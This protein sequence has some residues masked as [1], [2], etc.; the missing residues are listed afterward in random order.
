MQA[1]FTKTIRRCAN[2]LRPYDK[3][4][5]F[6]LNKYTLRIKD[7]E[8]DKEL[9]KRRLDRFH[10]LLNPIICLCVVTF[11]FFLAFDLLN[12]DMENMALICWMIPEAII[13]A[14]W[15]TFKQ[16]KWKKAPF[17]GFLFP[18]FK[19]VTLTL[20][21][22]GFLPPWI[23]KVDPEVDR[24]EIYFYLG[25]FCCLNYT[26]FLETAFLLPSLLLPFY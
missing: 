17:V 6:L 1:R 10:S 20:G 8:I 7:R 5:Y 2:S 12:E 11:L 14:I 18:F 13:I 19:V 4:T 22:W 15:A 16:Y 21:Y 3:G 9:S 26:S 25:G 24:M 23:K